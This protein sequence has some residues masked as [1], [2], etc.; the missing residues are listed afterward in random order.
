MITTQ[1]LKAVFRLLHKKQKKF[2]KW[3]FLS[4]FPH[5][6]GEQKEDFLC[7]VITCCTLE[8]FRTAPDILNMPLMTFAD[9]VIINRNKMQNSP[10]PIVKLKMFSSDRIHRQ[11]VIFSN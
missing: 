6:G 11:A 4:L 2:C 9:K 7:N 3:I 8:I 5:Q 1:E 10:S